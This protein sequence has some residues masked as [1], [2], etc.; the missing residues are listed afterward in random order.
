MPVETANREG[1]F[2]VRAR[3]H[4]A[5]RAGALVRGLIPLSAIALMV[6]PAII[7]Q[8]ASGLALGAL[9]A[10]WVVFAAAAAWLGTEASRREHV[11]LR[12]HI[13][14]GELEVRFGRGP[15]AYTRAYGP[16]EV[17]GIRLDRGTTSG[18]SVLLVPRTGTPVLLLEDMDDE[19]ECREVALVL[20]QGIGVPLDD[21]R[22]ATQGRLPGRVGRL[23]DGRRTVFS[24]D[25][26]DRFRP[27]GVLVGL[28]VVTCVAAC[29]PWL[30]SRLG[31]GMLLVAGADVVLA[32]GLLAHAVATLTVRRITVRDDAVRVERIFFSVPLMQEVVRFTDLT[33]VVVLRRGALTAVHIRASAGPRS[34]ILPFEEPRT[35]AWLK[36][37]IDK[38]AHE[39]GARMSPT[40]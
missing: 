28:A 25:Y 27:L 8:P 34:L 1:R 10:L 14:V 24:W 26:R 16:V 17:E 2:E 29:L 6:L 5:G 9:S 35:A 33:A 30:G 32:L 21:R 19:L 18:F 12:L 3:R 37:E 38:A 22:F 11:L 39:R 15:F 4:L 20:S 40:S 7:V 13:A 23:G 36:A 31:N